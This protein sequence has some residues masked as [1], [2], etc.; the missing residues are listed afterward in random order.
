MYL[1]NKISTI[2]KTVVLILLFR[3]SSSFGPL[4]LYQKFV[5]GIRISALLNQFCVEVDQAIEHQPVFTR[6][7]NQN[8][9]RLFH[10]QINSFQTISVARLRMLFICCT[11]SI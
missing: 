8:S 1:T 2:E 3:L 4:E 6:T 7:D 5:Y 10:A 11:H 9:F